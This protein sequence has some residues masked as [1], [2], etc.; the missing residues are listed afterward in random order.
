MR[1]IL[2]F[3]RTLLIASVTLS[4]LLV[5]LFRFINP[6]TN[7]YMMSE[8]I[9]LGEIKQTW[10]QIK[11]V[12]PHV[13][14]A[15]VAAEDANFCLHSGFDFASIREALSGKGR[16]RGASTISQ[17]VSKNVFLWQGRSWTRKGL[18]AGFT[19]LIEM[20]WPKKRILEVYMNI[21]EF[22]EGI[23]GIAAAGDQYFNVSPDQITRLQAA[24]LAAVLPSPKK[25]S[26]SRPNQT[27]RKRTRQ[28]L[29]GEETI[30]ADTRTDCF[31]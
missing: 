6:P 11:D 27:V 28:I 31:E 16:L 13:P 17:Q 9:R 20:I 25:R 10:V 8:W 4:V 19:I 12:P 18:E 22:D 30:A 14:R 2:R 15:L 26:A 3:I 29:S 5:I 7:F 23:F 21:A 1:I 24:R